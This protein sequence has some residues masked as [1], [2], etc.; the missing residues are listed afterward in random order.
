MKQIAMFALAVVLGLALSLTSTGNCAIAASPKEIEDARAAIRN[1]AQKTLALL[2]KAKPS[3]KTVIAKSAGYAVFSNFG[4]KIFLFGGGIGKGIAVDKKTKREIFMRMVEAQAGLGMGVKKYRLV[5]VFED[6]SEFQTFTE[7]GWRLGGQSSAV[8]KDGKE[9]G[10][11]E[12]AVSVSPGV[13]L[14]QMT[15]KGA[16]LDLTGKVSKF[17]KDDKLN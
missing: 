8:A 13:W 16:A 6:P 4:T 7:K 1:T 12:E 2:Y 3:A 17:Y 15:E 11:Y 5:I 10:A 14:Y 9:G